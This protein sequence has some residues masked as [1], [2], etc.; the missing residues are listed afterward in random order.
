M[1][2]NGILPTNNAGGI[3][4]NYADLGDPS[5]RFKD[6]Y[7]GGSITAGG[8]VTSTRGCN[9]K[10]VTNITKVKQQVVVVLD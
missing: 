6:L 10:Q 3:I 9:H 2:N 4:D 7:L 8:G 1:H 5:Y